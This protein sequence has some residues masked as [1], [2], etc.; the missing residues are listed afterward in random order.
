MVFKD[1]QNEEEL[2]SGGINKKKRFRI[3][4]IVTISLII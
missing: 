3:F 2:G 4:W 1:D